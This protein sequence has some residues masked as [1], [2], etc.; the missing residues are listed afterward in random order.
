M[1]MSNKREQRPIIE[2]ETVS[3]DVSRIAC[4]GGKSVR[5]HPRV[6]LNLGQEGRVQCPYCSKLY[7]RK[8][9]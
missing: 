1:A 6:F 5:G 7:V 3:A 2:Q 8:G 4:D 9:K